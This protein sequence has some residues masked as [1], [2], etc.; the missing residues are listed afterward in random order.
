M[1]KIVYTSPN[2]RGRLRE[3]PYTPE[4]ELEFYA[5]QTPK[6]M[7]RNLQQTPQASPQK[8]EPQEP[9]E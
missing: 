4:E 2:G 1:S 3:G 5:R 9:E 8:S 7:H 6:G